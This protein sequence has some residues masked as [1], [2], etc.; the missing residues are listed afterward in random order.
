MHLAQ[1]INDCA[2]TIMTTGTVNLW[3]TSTFHCNELV[4]WLACEQPRCLLDAY[5]EPI[6]RKFPLVMNQLEGLRAAIGCD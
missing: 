1:L 3:G 5:R 4:N 6:M 2:D